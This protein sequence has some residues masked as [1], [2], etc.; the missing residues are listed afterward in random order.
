MKHLKKP[1]AALDMQNHTKEAIFNKMNFFIRILCF[2]DHYRILKTTSKTM[3]KHPDHNLYSKLNK[4]RNWTNSKVPFLHFS[5]LI[6]NMHKSEQPLRSLK[7]KS[8]YTASSHSLGPVTRENELSIK[9]V[10]TENWY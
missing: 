2:T 10:G 4:Y 9:D 5:F 6:L 7:R 3:A 8:L 1:N